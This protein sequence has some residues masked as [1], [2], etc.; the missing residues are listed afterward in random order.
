MS[1][2]W[3]YSALNSFE[4]CPKK[5][6]HTRVVKDIKEPPIPESSYGTQAHKALELR[7]AKGKALPPQF[8][9]MEPIIARLANAKGDKLPEQELAINASFRPT[10]WWSEDVWCRAK[11]DLAIVN[12]PNAVTIDYKTGKFDPDFTQQRLATALLM[13]HNRAIQK[14][15][16]LYIW[17]KTKTI[18]PQEMTRA[19]MTEFWSEIMPRVKKYQRAFEISEFPA[20]K[21]GLCRRHCPVTACIYNGANQ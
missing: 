17:L 11:L 16:V 12:G 10:G 4:T 21:N 2:P 6:W 7:V 14:A 20:K 3:S 15:Q 13:L 19:D 5:H 18:S 9:Q 1:Q 8:S